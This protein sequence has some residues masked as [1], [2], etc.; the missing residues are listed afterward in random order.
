MERGAEGRHEGAH[1]D[2]VVHQWAG[3]DSNRRLTDYESV[4]PDAQGAE[5]AQ[6]AK[7]NANTAAHSAARSSAKADSQAPPTGLIAPNADAIAAP[8]LATVI[9][10]WPTLPEHLRKAILAIVEAAKSAR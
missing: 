9:D 8:D 5:N 4:A 6:V 2:D 7:S 1:T 10:A 3:S